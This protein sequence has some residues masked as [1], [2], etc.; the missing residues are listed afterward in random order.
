MFLSLMIPE[1]DR[2]NVKI[3]FTTLGSR[4]SEVQIP[5]HKKAGKSRSDPV[6]VFNHP[7]SV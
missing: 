6:I 5:H 7:V 3:S 2:Q 4:G 1:I